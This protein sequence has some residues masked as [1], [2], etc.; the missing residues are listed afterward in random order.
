MVRTVGGMVV[1][2]VYIGVIQS[3][4]SVGHGYV[5]TDYYDN[6]D[7]FYSSTF[8]GASISACVRSFHI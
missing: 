3:G 1:M 2:E 5:G 8:V 6:S 4:Y 7:H